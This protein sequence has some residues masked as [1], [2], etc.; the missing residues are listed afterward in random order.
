[1]NQ[2]NRHPGEDP[3]KKA[4]QSDAQKLVRE[5]MENK[6]HVISDEEFKNIQVGARNDNDRDIDRLVEENKKKEDKA[7]P[8]SPITPWDALNP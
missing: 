7:P 6:D 3:A 4:P 2:H 5:H 1:M 8:D